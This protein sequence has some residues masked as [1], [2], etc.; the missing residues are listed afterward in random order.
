MASRMDAPNDWRNTAE[1]KG[2]AESTQS[3]RKTDSSESRIRSVNSN[4]VECLSWLW[5]VCDLRIDPFPRRF[6]CCHANDFHSLHTFQRLGSAPN[7]NFASASSAAFRW[8]FSLGRATC[9]TTSASLHYFD[10]RH[11]GTAALEDIR[12]NDILGERIAAIARVSS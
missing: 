2:S 9:I 3:F 7:E 6:S 8:R 12:W 5:L 11:G 1:G 10:R 4:F